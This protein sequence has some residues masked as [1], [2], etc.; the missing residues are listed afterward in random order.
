MGAAS[1]EP[2][3]F[4]R[5][6]MTII[7]DAVDVP[8][9]DHLAD[10]T[11]PIFAVGAAGGLG[12]LT[13]YTTTLTGTSDVTFLNVS[14]W[15]P[16]AIMLDFGHIDLWTAENAEA[17]VWAPILEWVNGHTPDEGDWV[18]YKEN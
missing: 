13:E 18:A 2:N 11:N 14:L 12:E 10:I 1:Y 6:Y 16:E 8:W 4:M 5:E 15:P 17:L 9:D 7:C 3:A